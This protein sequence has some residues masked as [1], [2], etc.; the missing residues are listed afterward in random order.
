VSTGWLVWAET[1]ANP[2]LTPTRNEMLAVED[3]ER[4][5]AFGPLGTDLLDLLARADLALARF[6]AT[7]TSMARAQAALSGDEALLGPVEMARTEPGG[8]PLRWQLLVPGGTP[9]CRPWP[10]LIELADGSA[11]ASDAEPD[12]PNGATRLCELHL[13]VADPAAAHGLY[14]ALGLH[15][16][17]SGRA[18]VGDVGVWLRTCAEPE[19]T[20]AGLRAVSVTVADLDET[21]ARLGWAG[22]RREP[23][24]L[25]PDPT[26]SVGVDIRFR[27]RAVRRE[28][29]HH[30]ARYEH[31]GWPAG[32]EISTFGGWA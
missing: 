21:A 13:D 26:A 20:R 17:T 10:M 27:R 25:V 12:H 19:R 32:A 23:D 28:R 8:R 16:S 30:P 22:Y 18:D 15:I 5:A 11:P 24:A 29:P 4:V 3:E 2:R 14:S 7:V 6:A 9:W 31:A 1:P